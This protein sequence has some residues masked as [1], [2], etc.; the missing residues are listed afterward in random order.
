MAHRR[1]SLARPLASLAAFGA[2]VLLAQTGW[3]IAPR[4]VLPN[5]VPS[6]AVGSVANGVAPATVVIDFRLYLKGRLPRAEQRFASQV[7]Q[8]GS[9]LFRHYL[10]PGQFKRRFAPAGAQIRAVS[11]WARANGLTVTGR[12]EHFVALRGTAPAISQALHTKIDDYGGTLAHPMGYAPVSGISVPFS[13]GADVL[14]AVGLDND[15]YGSAPDAAPERQALG[16]RRSGVLHC[17]SWWGQH[18]SAIP[19]AYGRTT[20]PTANCGY[21]PEQLR[22]AYGV[23]RFTG[24]GAT[25]A[26][27]LDGSLRTMR[28]DANRFFAAHHVRGFAPGQFSLNHG[29]G[30]ASSCGPTYADLPE[31]PLDVETAHIIAP[32][33]R[34]VYVAVNCSQSSTRP[35]VNFLDAET[36]IVDHHLA[37]VETDSYSTLESLYT[38]AMV[39]AW[40][41]ILEQGAIE[42]IGFNFDSGDGG[43]DTNN[44]PG[45]PPAILFPASDPWATAVGGTALQIGP[46]GHVAGQVGWGDTI[47]R[48]NATHSGYLQKP[49]G[50]F[51][52][53]STGGPSQLFGQPAYQRTVVP[54]SLATAGGKT[55]PRRVTPD[56]AADADPLT[57]WLIA[58]TQDGRY[59]QVIEGGTSGASPIIASLEADAKQ[60]SGRAVGFANPTLY[61]LSHR[62]LD[63]ILPTRRATIV[64]APRSDC[65]NGAAGS[66]RC[67][68]TLG[69]DSS[70]REARGFDA[71]TGLGA[72]GAR[73]IQAV[74]RPESGHP[75]GPQLTASQTK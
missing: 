55:S 67:L 52:E 29:P 13:L 50:I 36:R 61:G 4:A 64:L 57:G 74:A 39:A 18:R 7:S 40:T 24:R 41:K 56:I 11:S 66:G 58:F 21:T 49:P 59:Q 28:A 69:L 44:E 22:Q 68:V 2:A 16:P 17:S 75:A 10:T 15:L 37:D 1:R 63:D 46:S 33:A 70:L 73:F 8:P 47:A 23:G 45:V 38:P 51:S 53:G 34:V 31:E 20:A 72:P 42:G 9:T 3:A 32:R 25:I 62:A 5:P 12:G 14:T 6:W 48:E 27:V 26:I 43:D 54:R 19:K 30:F 65:Y 35:E 60:A 71:V